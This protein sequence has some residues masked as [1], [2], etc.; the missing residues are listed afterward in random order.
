M[1]WSRRGR[2]G[3]STP[4]RAASK[5]R[6]N[7]RITRAWQAAPWEFARRSLRVKLGLLTL[8]GMASMALALGALMF[9]TANGLFLQQARA[10]LQRRN[11]SAAG[12][13]DDLTARAAQALLL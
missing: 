2:R 9:S 11:Q 5:T 6:V 4:Q 8:L 1:Q 10:E 13:I 12:D 3:R 7:P